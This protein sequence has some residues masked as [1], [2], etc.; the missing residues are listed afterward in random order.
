MKSA[1]L[2]AI[3]LTCCFAS[4]CVTAADYTRTV[5]TRRDANEQVEEINITKSGVLKGR[6]G[7]P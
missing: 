4:G 1:L 5:E 6:F 2:L 3:L 7:Y